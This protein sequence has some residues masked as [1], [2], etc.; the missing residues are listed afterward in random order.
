MVRARLL[1]ERAIRR[2]WASGLLGGTGGLD[3][4]ERLL[5]PTP[6]PDAGP[7]LLPD[8][9]YR[10]DD[11][12]GA[13]GAR[14]GLGPSELD[15]I[16]VLL[17]AETDPVASRLVGY[18]GEATSHDL[19]MMP[20]VLAGSAGGKIRA[21]RLLDWSSARRDSNQMLVS[22]AHA[23][24]VTDLTSFGDASGATGPLPNLAA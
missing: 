14:L 2:R 12:V 4:I 13:Y 17:A 22:I 9:V 21:G 19:M 5:D 3:A 7:A 8:H 1:V 18:L 6:A 10:A 11:P 20:Y 16:G 24:G 15:L 23:M